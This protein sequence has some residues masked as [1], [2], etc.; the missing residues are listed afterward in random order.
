MYNDKSV[1]ENYHV[2]EAFKIMSTPAANIFARMSPEEF[3]TVRRF[4]IA[5][6]LAT[7]MTKHGYLL[8][9][10]DQLG[11]R[12]GLRSE[13]PSTLSWHQPC[14]P[15]LPYHVGLDAAGFRGVFLGG[16]LEKVAGD[17]SVIF[18]GSRERADSE[19]LGWLYQRSCAS[20]VSDFGGLYSRDDPYD[21]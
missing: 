1:L 19:L 3:R 17:W 21:R 12:A 6:V 15:I 2:A 16:G 20:A 7:D 4:L 10:N 13:H 5:W 8:N 14:L 9:K 11:W 18:G